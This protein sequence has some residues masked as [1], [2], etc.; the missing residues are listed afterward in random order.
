MDGGNVDWVLIWSSG[1]VDREFFFLL[2]RTIRREE[3][4]GKHL[5]LNLVYLEVDCECYVTCFGRFDVK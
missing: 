3:L 2:P 5:E 4:F 1:Y